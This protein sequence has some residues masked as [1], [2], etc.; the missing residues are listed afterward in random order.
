MHEKW[1]NELYFKC[2]GKIPFGFCIFKVSESDS[3]KPVF[4][5]CFL[6]EIWII[7]FV[8]VII[9]LSFMYTDD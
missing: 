4:C 9:R 6:I 2:I 5:L 1:T 3:E 8:S 7:C